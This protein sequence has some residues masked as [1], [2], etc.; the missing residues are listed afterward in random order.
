[1]RYAEMPGSLFLVTG[2]TA[3]FGSNIVGRLVR[4]SE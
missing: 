2:G 1:M 3:L 4:A